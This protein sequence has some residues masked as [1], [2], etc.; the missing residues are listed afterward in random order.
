[1]L[2]QSTRYKIFQ[3][4]KAISDNEIIV[5]EQRKQLALQNGFEP[6]AAFKRIDR[7]GQGKISAGD[8]NDFLRENMVDYLSEVECYHMFQFFDSDKDGFLDY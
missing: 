1:M 6:W 5:E 7:G 4:F 2:G 8:I 3:L